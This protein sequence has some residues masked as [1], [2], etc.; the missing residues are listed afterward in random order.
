MVLAVPKSVTVVQ[1]DRLGYCSDAIKVR[2][3]C[4]N[5]D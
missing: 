4:R 3:T 1:M 2:R 5:T